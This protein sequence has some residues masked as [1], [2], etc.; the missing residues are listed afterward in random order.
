MK[1]LECF[2][3]SRLRSVSNGWNV[4]GGF[5]E[6]WNVVFGSTGMFCFSHI[7]PLIFV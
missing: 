2:V 3:I 7:T 6:G 4:E 1:C 5:L